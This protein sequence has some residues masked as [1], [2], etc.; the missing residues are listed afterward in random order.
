[1]IEDAIK[2]TIVSYMRSQNRPYSVHNVFDNLRGEV[3]K[4]K[5]LAAL[6]VCLILLSVFIQP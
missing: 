5:A 6:E 1:M 4:A 2:E 3:P